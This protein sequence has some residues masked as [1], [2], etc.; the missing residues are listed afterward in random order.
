VFEDP[1]R[2][3]PG[4]GVDLVTLAEVL[5]QHSEGLG[6]ELLEGGSTG[7]FGGRLARPADT[8]TPKPNYFP[9]SPGRPYPLD[10]LQAIP[11]HFG[12]GC[13]QLID[14]SLPIGIKC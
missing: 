10:E 5:L 11:C 14:P 9:L 4:L 8:H 3:L 13:A 2:C 6:H 7:L 12:Q 1:E